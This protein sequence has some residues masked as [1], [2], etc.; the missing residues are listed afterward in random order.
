MRVTIALFFLFASILVLTGMTITPDPENFP[1][2]QVP[3]SQIYTSGQPSETGFREAA[4]L[5]VKTVVNVLPERECWKAETA[6]VQNNGMRYVAIP[7]STTNFDKQTIRKFDSVMKSARKPLLIHCSTGNHAGG[8]WFAYRVLIEKASS[9]IALKEAREIGLKPELE[10][11]L[12]KWVN[13]QA[14]F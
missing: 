6:V 2:L 1:N 5:G 12:V 7:F 10:A 8:L 11:R 14:R 4:A 3:R 9:E 13:G